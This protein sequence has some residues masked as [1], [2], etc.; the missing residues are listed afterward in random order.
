MKTANQGFIFFLTLSLLSM[1]SLLLLTS[2]AHVLLYHK[3]INKLDERNRDFYALEQVVLKLSQIPFDDNS[4]VMPAIGANKTLSL[5]SQNARCSLSENNRRYQYV[6]EDL[7]IVPCL[8]TVAKETSHHRRITVGV[9]SEEG[10]LALLQ[11]RVIQATPAASQCSG[12]AQTI[13][14]GISSWRYLTDI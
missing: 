13:K 6:I 14:P 11:V 12:M 2:M 7:G 3:I 4:C 1:M 8:I 5:I 10:R 9:R